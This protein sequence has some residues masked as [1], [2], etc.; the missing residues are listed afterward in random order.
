MSTLDIFLLAVALA[1]DCFA[2]S[3]VSGVVLRRLEWRL[4]WWMS[5]L[6][7]F[8]QALMPWLGWVS[9]TWLTGYVASYAH[10]V[11]FLL[12]SFVGGRMVYESF[13]P[14]EQS[15]FNPHSLRMQ[16]LLAVATSIDALAVGVTFAMVGYGS[17]ASLCPVLLLIGLVSLLAGIVGQWLG[18]GWGDVL[19]RRVRPELLGGLLLLLLGLKILLGHYL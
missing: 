11:A 6:F 17:W 10:W 16:L 18:V 14:E 3:V 5:F 1:M 9:V 13:S 12:L 2:V 4:V 15:S 8:F 7:G 19:S